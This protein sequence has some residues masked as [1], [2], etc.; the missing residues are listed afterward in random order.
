V[1]GL[2]A[3]AVIALYAAC[4]LEIDRVALYEPPLI[5]DGVRPDAWAPRYERELDRGDLAAA[6]VTI[7]KGTGDVGSPLTYAPRFLLK[8]LFG[9]A[10]RM[11]KPSADRVPLRELVPTLREDIKLVREA[12]LLIENFAAIPSDVLLLGGARSARD[13]RVSLRELARRM[14]RARLV[15][16]DKV[17]HTAALDEDQPELVAQQLR[18]F[19][20]G[21]S[22]R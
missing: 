2:S 14:P 5:V 7:L 21:A 22:P 18:A 16:L 13:L 6:L 20:A 1:F 4:Q 15:V 8:P 3:G 11:E 19:F 12:S 17:G 9:L 10:I